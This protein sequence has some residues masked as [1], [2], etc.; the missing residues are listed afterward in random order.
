[1]RDVIVD[2]ARAQSTEKRGGAGIPASMSDLGPIALTDDMVSSDDIL[3]LTEALGR[4][5]ALD[6]EAAHVVELRYYAGLTIEETA[7]ALA[8]ST[9]TVSR[10]WALAR[11]WLHRELGSGS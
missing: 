6:A 1:M 9:A 4:L 8:I 2:Y 3:A 5:E 7:E 10:R 11:A